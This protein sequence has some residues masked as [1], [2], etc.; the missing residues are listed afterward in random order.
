MD[1]R[2]GQ[3]LAMAN[4]P[5]LDP[6]NANNV[7]PTH[8]KNRSITDPFEPGSVFKPFMHAA[9]S[10]EKLAF[11]NTMVDATLTGVWVTPHGRRLHDV[12]PHGLITWDKGLVVSSN[13]V[14]GKICSQMG[15]KKMHGWVTAFGFGS[16]TGTGL[17]GESPG[18]VNPLKKW[19]PYS[20]TSLPMGQE[21]SVTSMQMVRALS[22]FANGGMMVSPSIL[23]EEASSPIMQKVL[24]PKVA[25]HTRDLMRL[26]V[27]EGTGKRALSD[28]YQIWG[29]TG[30]AQ[31]ALPNGAGY[32]PRAYNASFIG[33]APLADPRIVV[34]VTVTEPDPAVAHYGGVVSAP[35]AK[36]I[37]EQSLTYMAVPRDAEGADKLDKDD[38]DDNAPANRN[39]N[40][41][42]ATRD[43][44]D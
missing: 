12:H 43:L 6:N 13:I 18:I 2:T 24:D 32:K 27:T 35:V 42:V 8:R 28:L 44:A 30:T 36:N 7:K 3:V 11:P 10:Q 25:N 9:A 17:P 21:I 41:T 40:R 38:K 16:R 23:A 39:S 34:M 14:M 31:I 37:I 26:V 29:K 20:L 4:W 22:V 19:G 5:K 15:Y 1:T 33:G